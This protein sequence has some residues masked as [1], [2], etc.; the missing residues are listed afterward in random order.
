MRTFT[1][2]SKKD[3]NFDKFSKLEW[4]DDGKKKKGLANDSDIS[5]L[6]LFAINIRDRCRGSKLWQSYTLRNVDGLKR[7]T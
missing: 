7:K 1:Y 3:E 4:F 6:V 5:R 2:F